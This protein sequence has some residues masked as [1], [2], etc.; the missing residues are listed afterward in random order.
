MYFYLKASVVIVPNALGNYSGA[1][2]SEWEIFNVNK[3]L[4]LLQELVHKDHEA[5]RYDHRG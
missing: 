4:V 3:S 2:S 1:A 5:V